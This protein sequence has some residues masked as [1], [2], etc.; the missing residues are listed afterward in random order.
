[1]VALVNNDCV[2]EPG[3][4]AFCR[5]A[6][7]RDAGLAAAQGLIL[8]GSGARVDGCGIGWNARAEAIQLRHGE[9][10]P[11]LKT[12]FAVTGV[13]GTAPLFR[14]A[15]FLEAGGFEES[16]FA[17]YEDADL[18]LRLLRRGGRFACVP[19]ARARHLGSATGSRDPRM[20]WR[21]LF[22]NRVRT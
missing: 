18:A 9:A 22:A 14:R 20:R 5:E 7:E 16:F 4:L 2:L 8:D 15:V 6:L 21:R 3:Y 17:Y 13:S 10:V 19:E 11:D 1:F 12:P